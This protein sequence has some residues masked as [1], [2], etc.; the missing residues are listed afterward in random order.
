MKRT[1]LDIIVVF[2][3][4]S[5]ILYFSPSSYTVSSLDFSSLSFSP[6]I[7]HEPIIINSNEGFLDYGF[8]GTGTKEDPFIIENLNITTSDDDGISINSTSK[9]FII[10]NCYLDSHKIGIGIRYVSP[11]TTS[12]VN[13]TCFYSRFHG[14]CMVRTDNALIANN[15]CAHNY[16]LGIFLNTCNNSVIKGNVLFNNTKGGLDV[17]YSLHPLIEDNY[18]YDNTY[19]GGIRLLRTN[20]AEIRNNTLQFDRSNG[21]QLAL[22]NNSIVADNF[23]IYCLN[24]ILLKWSENNEIFNN[25][26]IT[27]GYG[28]II[29]DSNTSTILSNNLTHNYAGICFYRSLD[30]AVINNSC[31]DNVYG[32]S[33]FNSNTSTFSY[34][35]IQN[36]TLYGVT[37]DSLSSS[38]LFHHNAFIRN[39]PEGFSQAS[40]NGTDNNWYY[41][42]KGNYWSDWLK[43]DYLIDGTVKSVD[44]HPLSEYLKYSTHKTS[45]DSFWGVVFSLFLFTVVTRVII[46]KRAR[47]FVKSFNSET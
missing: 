14:I 32:M 6:L 43:G 13:N 23:F 40:D 28:I 20:N 17:E 38:N 45:L 42:R 2:L 10:R 24:G 19:Y 9:H 21:I 12:V 31:Y 3:V 39:N 4:S 22:S 47:L 34:N 46:L 26:C 30:F 8:P 7:P 37:L 36:S 41:K 25:T 15:T 1:F 33:I 35:I 18:I 29:V 5:T 44:R 16:W 27:G 11:G